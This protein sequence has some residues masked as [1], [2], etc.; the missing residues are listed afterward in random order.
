LEEKCLHIGNI[1]LS[2][3]KSDFEIA[4]DHIWNQQKQ[5]ADGDIEGLKFHSL[6]K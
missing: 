3:A 1:V 6:Q 5:R 4:Q 2:E